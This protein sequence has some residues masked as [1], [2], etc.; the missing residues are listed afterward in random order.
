MIVRPYLMVRLMLGERKAWIFKATVPI[1]GLGLLYEREL[2]FLD[3]RIKT[4]GFWLSLLDSKIQY[5]R[6]V[7]CHPHSK[8]PL[9]QVVSVSSEELWCP[10]F[11]SKFRGKDYWWWSWRN[12]CSFVSNV[13]W[14]EGWSVSKSW[15][16]KEENIFWG[17]F[18][19]RRHKRRFRLYFFKYRWS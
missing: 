6:G 9:I 5:I 7:P 18:V 4:L 19:F 17:W 14:G 3:S 1:K 13:S 2:Q 15:Y 16:W 11:S 8:S 10:C 12:F